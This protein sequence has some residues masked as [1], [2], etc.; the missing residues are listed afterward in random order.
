MDDTPIKAAA[1]EVSNVRWARVNSEPFEYAIQQGPHGDEFVKLLD[2]SC[3]HRCVAPAGNAGEREALHPATADLVQRFAT[4]LAAKL[5]AAEVKYGYSTG[6]RDDAWQEECRAG[7]MKHVM[8]GD[9]LDVAAFAAFCWDRRWSAAPMYPDHEDAF[10]PLFERWADAM[11]IGDPD[12]EILRRD[13]RAALPQPREAFADEIKRA[14][15]APPEASFDNASDMLGYLNAPAREAEPDD[16]RSDPSADE[17]WN[18]GLD[19][20]MNLL[21]DYLGVDKNEVIWDAATETVEGDV[22]AV[23]GNILR[24]KYGENWSPASPS[25]IPE[26]PVGREEIIEECAKVCDRWIKS[27]NLHEHLAATDIARDIR[28]LKPQDGG[29][30]C[31]TK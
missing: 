23:I 17:R 2:G 16:W 9:P 30:R 29:K 24:T 5:R 20:G 25:P 18:L 13:V 14:D 8:K 21:C 6:W 4:A 31:S 12:R 19:F 3:L 27:K 7:L 22:S 28:A 1:G 11:L 15:D 26:A 10:L